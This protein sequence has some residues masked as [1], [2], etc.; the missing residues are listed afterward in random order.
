MKNG[1]KIFGIFLMTMLILLS[2]VNVSRVSVYGDTT[3]QKQYVY[4][5][6]GLYSD[7]ETETL[8]ALCR[9]KSQ[10]Q[11]I[12]FVIL[13]T[14]E[15]EGKSS[16]TYSD[17]F[18]DENHLGFEDD[19]R[20]DKS[21]VLLLFD[22]DNK[23]VY[24][25]TTGIAILCI[26]DDDIENI[27]DEVFEYIPQKDYV[28]AAKAFINAA[29]KVITSNKKSYAGKYLDEWEDF[30]GTYE[31][32]DRTYVHVR[33]NVFYS[34]KNPVT[35]VII[36][37][38]VAGI[39]T[40]ILAYSNKARMTANRFTYMNKRDLRIHV[41]NDFFIRT[42]TRRYKMSSSSGGGGGGSYHSSGG[43]HSHGGGGRH[44]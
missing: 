37:L 25:N 9:E 4:D 35:C 14:S 20:W 29:D 34:L 38:L 26:E 13:A 24:I 5:F 39:V 44:M 12:D 10:K 42:T 16:M 23:E 41:A 17:D 40:L 30:D 11:K 43:G 36:S 8:T 27:L 32:F 3:G 21:C 22:F 19:G 1:K 15:A 33:H 28:Q 6:S 7:E 31:E 18:M 2:V